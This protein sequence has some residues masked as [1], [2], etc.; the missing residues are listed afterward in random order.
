LW[1]NTI[2]GKRTV[3]ALSIPYFFVAPG[4]CTKMCTSGF[5]KRV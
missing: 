1:G 4:N 5:V 3:Q 2:R